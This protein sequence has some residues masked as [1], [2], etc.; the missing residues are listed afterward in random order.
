MDTLLTKVQSVEE[1][2]E[3]LLARAEEAG[4]KNVADVRGRESQMME[5]VRLAAQ[6]RGEQIVKEKVAQASGQI[7]K[8]QDEEE[9]ALKATRGSAEKN[10]KEVVAAAIEFFQKDYLN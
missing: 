7:N 3:N 9:A 10:R 4:Q 8:I 2:A 5:E 1:E 6:K